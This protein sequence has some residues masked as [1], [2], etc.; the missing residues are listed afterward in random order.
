MQILSKAQNA[1]NTGRK[2]GVGTGGPTLMNVELRTSTGTTD[3]DWSCPTCR[4]EQNV[5]QFVTIVYDGT[6]LNWYK[7]GVPLHQVPKTGNIVGT[8]SDLIIGSFADRT[9]SFFN[10]AIDDVRIYNRA[11]SITEIWD[12]VQL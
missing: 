9:Q 12:L 4:L 10:G 2:Y 11:L 7:D 8:T 1:S 3:Q 5:W 6:M